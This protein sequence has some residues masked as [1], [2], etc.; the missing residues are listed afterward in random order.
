MLGS[1]L[2][3]VIYALVLEM[4]GSL[5]LEMTEALVLELE[6]PD[7]LVLKVLGFLKVRPR[8]LASFASTLFNRGLEMSQNIL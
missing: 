3:K 1:L 5:V 7:S 2:L 8:S 6:M 4:L